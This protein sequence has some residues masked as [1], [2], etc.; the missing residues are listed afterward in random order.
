MLRNAINATFAILVCVVGV[1][2]FSA[3]DERTKSKTVDLAEI[4]DG[5]VEIVVSDRLPTGDGRPN[6]VAFN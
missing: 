3:A 2:M 4:V 6:A 1:S 5:R